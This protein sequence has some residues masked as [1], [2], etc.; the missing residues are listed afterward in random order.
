MQQLRCCL[1]RQLQLVVGAKKVL[2]LQ[3]MVEATAQ[4]LHPAAAL[5]V[6]LQLMVP[7]ELQRLHQRIVVAKLHQLK[8]T[9]SQNYQLRNTITE[10]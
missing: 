4:L 8:L 9:A 1:L 10:S 6:Q 2:V 5:V 7:V 3:L